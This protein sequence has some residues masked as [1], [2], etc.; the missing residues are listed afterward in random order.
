[1][2]DLIFQF[3]YTS[4]P[5]TYLSCISP[6]EFFKEE[7][8]HFVFHTYYTGLFNNVVLL[9]GSAL[10]PW[11]SLHDPNDLRVRVAKQLDCDY[12]NDEDIAECL[13]TKSLEDLLQL[14][15]NEIKYVTL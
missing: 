2:T 11:A 6:L 3:T 15:L 1:M 8:E 9:S 13:R 12:Q 10:S 5:K 14:D 4:L 7:N